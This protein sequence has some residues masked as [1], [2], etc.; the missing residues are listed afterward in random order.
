MRFAWPFTEAIIS[1]DAS[2]MP[3]GLMLALS[4]FVVSNTSDCVRVAC[5]FRSN[6]TRKMS[7]F[8]TLQCSGETTELA[9]AHPIRRAS[10]VDHCGVYPYWKSTDCNARLWAEQNICTKKSVARRCS[11]S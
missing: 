8:R 2:R 5:S 11:G 10:R 3:P 9:A 1:G 4:R 6:T 7:H